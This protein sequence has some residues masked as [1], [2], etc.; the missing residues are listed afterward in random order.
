MSATRCIAFCPSG[1]VNQ[2]GP[3]NHVDPKNELGPE[4]QVGPKNMVAPE[5]QVGHE[6]QARLRIRLGPSMGW[7]RQ[8]VIYMI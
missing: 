8:L 4:N 6:N 1:L 2:V 5:D 3:N 7:G